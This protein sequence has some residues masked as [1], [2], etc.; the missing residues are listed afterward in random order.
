MHLDK[1][2]A[3]IEKRFNFMVHFGNSWDE[4]LK[5]EFDKEYYLKSNGGVTFS[6]GEVLLQAVSLIPLLKML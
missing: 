3:S 4:V 2:C 6:G 1:L 5:G